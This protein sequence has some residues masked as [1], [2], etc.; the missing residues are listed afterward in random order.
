MIEDEGGMAEVFGADCTKADE[1]EA[2]VQAAVDAFGTV[3]ILVNN[4]GLAAVGTVVDMTEEDVGPRRS[5]STCAP[6]SSR[7]STSCR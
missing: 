6:P 7:R 4:I 2:M 3:D 5:T 1:C